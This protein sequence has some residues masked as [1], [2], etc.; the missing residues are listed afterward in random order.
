MLDQQTFVKRYWMKFDR[1]KKQMCFS[2]CWMRL[3]DFSNISS[4]MSFLGMCRRLLKGVTAKNYQMME[5]LGQ[6][7]DE[8]LDAPDHSMI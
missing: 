7:L 5:M 3:T 8:I 6:M 4:N 1:D 2:N